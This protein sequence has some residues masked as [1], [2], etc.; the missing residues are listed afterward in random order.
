MAY[1]YHDKKSV[2]A[3]AAFEH[4]KLVIRAPDPARPNQSEYYFQLKYPLYSNLPLT[5]FIDLVNGE[6]AAFKRFFAKDNHS[7]GF[8][9]SRLYNYILLH[10]WGSLQPRANKHIWYDY[11][12][13]PE[14]YWVFQSH[15]EFPE[16]G[17]FNPIAL[18]RDP[19]A[20]WC[21]KKPQRTASH[22]LKTKSIRYNTNQ[23]QP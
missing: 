12:P 18:S 5:K 11:Q 13:V 21:N 23:N 2:Q 19:T 17:V 16:I 8:G 4:C 22:W 6:K 3:A 10:E 20:A 1:C 14:K 7:S 15:W 9:S